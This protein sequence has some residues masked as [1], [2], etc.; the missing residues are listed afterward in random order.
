MYQ[1]VG[2]MCLLNLVICVI[3]VLLVYVLLIL[4]SYIQMCLPMWLMKKGSYELESFRML[5][6]NFTHFPYAFTI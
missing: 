3:C 6:I 2:L 5:L 4:L 1:P